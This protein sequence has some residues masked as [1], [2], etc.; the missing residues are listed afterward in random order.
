MSQATK[1]ILAFVAFLTGITVAN[2]IL[3]QKWLENRERAR[4]T[5]GYL[6]VT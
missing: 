5:V 1:L 6:P 4:M 2:G 3:N